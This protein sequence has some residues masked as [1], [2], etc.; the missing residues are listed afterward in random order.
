MPLFQNKLCSIT[1]IFFFFLLYSINI[2]AQFRDKPE[3]EIVGDPLFFIDG[4]EMLKSEMA[5]VNANDIAT[6]TVLKDGTSKKYGE[7]GKNG[8]VLIE[9]KVYCRQRFQHYLSEKSAEYKKI[10]SEHSNDQNIQYILNEKVLKCC[11]WKGL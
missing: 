7:K 5:N 11:F 8:V 10:L 6:V 9:T 3:K 1:A 4:K 2:L